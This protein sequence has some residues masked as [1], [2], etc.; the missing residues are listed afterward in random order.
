MATWRGG[1]HGEGEGLEFGAIG[2]LPVSG[3]GGVCTYVCMYVCMY[4]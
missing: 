2:S 1:F 4:V 3:G